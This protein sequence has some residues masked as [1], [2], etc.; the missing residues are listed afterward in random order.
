MLC[1][2]PCL[3]Q[4]LP[5]I[6]EGQLYM[7]FALP[8]RC[9]NYALLSD[10]HNDYQMEYKRVLWTIEQHQSSWPFH[11]RGGKSLQGLQHEPIHCADICKLFTWKFLHIYLFS[12]KNIST[13][14]TLLPQQMLL[15]TLSNGQELVWSLKS[16]QGDVNG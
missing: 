9:T 3:K 2:S 12:V 14:V 6:R 4:F 5:I 11:T 13:S 1:I 8:K 7:T 15:A 10:I 16:K